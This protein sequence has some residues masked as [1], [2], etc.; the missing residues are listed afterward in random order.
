MKNLLKLFFLLGLCTSILFS[1]QENKDNLQPTQE[2]TPPETFGLS[3]TS[4]SVLAN[5]SP[6]AVPSFSGTMPANFLL[7]MP[8]VGNQGKEGSCVAWAVAY[9]TRSYHMPYKP[10]NNA[11]IRC[12]EYVYNQIKVTGC[13]SVS[14]FVNSGVYKGALNLLKDEGVC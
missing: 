1:C 14:Y 6:F 2:D 8:E 9:A 13:E 5:V 4:A 11:I 10:Y 3:P 7:Q 12:P